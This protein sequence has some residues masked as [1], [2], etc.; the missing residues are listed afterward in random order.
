MKL[1][2]PTNIM[3]IKFKKILN[4]TNS[5]S[6]AHRTPKSI[7]MTFSRNFINPN[8]SSSK[9]KVCTNYGPMSIPHNFARRIDSIK[10]LVSKTLSTTGSGTISKMLITLLRLDILI[11]SKILLCAIMPRPMFLLNS[12]L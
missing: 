10:Y 1:Y 6:W 8:G 7:T 12:Y 3:C 11:F 9:I 5:L 2:Q 4:Y